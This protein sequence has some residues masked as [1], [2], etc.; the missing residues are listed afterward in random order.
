MHKFLRSPTFNFRLI[1]I[2]L[3]ACATSRL[4]IAFRRPCFI[5]KVT[6]SVFELS[7]QVTRV[8]QVID[9]TEPQTLG[10]IIALKALGRDCTNNNELFHKMG[11]L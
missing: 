10:S 4:A 9:R 6:L 11:V 7:T 5:N 2:N 3:Y 8:T 1:I